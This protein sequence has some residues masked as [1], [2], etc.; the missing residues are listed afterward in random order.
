MSS[1]PDRSDR[2][3]AEA[4]VIREARAHDADALSAFALD[5]FVTT[6]GPDNHPDDMAA[7]CAM[8]FTPAVQAREIADPSR[9]YLLAESHGALAAYALLR[10]GNVEPNVTGPSPVEVERFYVAHAW[11]GTGVAHALMTAVLETARARGGETLWLGVWDR[12]PRAIRFYAKHGFVD[13]GSHAFVLGTDPQTDRVMA[14]A[15]RPTAAV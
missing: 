8:A 15:L 14:R 1:A 5:V 11:H 6:F 7:Y 4:V 13:V 12:N 2:A 10:V 9:I 3:T